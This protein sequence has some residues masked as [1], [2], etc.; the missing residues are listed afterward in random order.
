[1]QFSESGLAPLPVKHNLKQRLEIKTTRI[2]FMIENFFFSPNVKEVYSGENGILRFVQNK[3]YRF[4][5]LQHGIFLWLVW[6]YILSLKIQL[7]IK[8][9]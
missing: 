6:S 4:L 2:L 3:I 9:S 8:Y 7:I 1:M 5:K